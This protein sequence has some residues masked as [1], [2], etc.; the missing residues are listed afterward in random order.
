MHT[1]PVEA[2]V[3]RMSVVGLDFQLYHLKCLFWNRCVDR[4]ELQGIP[5]HCIVG[6]APQFN[7]V[8]VMLRPQPVDDELLGSRLKFPSG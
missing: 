2:S 6:I 4:E 8:S 5:L 1:E 7:W 3:L